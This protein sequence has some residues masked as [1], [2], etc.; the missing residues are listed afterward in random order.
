MNA[1][2]KDDMEAEQLIAGQSKI[3][4]EQ[5]KKFFA[6]EYENPPS[7]HDKA[8]ISAMMRTLTPFILNIAAQLKDAIPDPPELAAAKK[9]LELM[10]ERYQPSDVKP[11][12]E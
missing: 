12:G 6:E 3:L 1:K 2:E 8:L 5:A 9:E 7:M 10:R 4:T 11:V